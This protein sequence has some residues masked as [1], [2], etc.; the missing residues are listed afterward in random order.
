[1][2]VELARSM[3][4]RG[5]KSFALAAR[6]LPPSCRDDVA[7]LY[8]Y[9]RR[10]DDLIDDAPAAEQ[11]ARIEA[12]SAELASVYAR[13]PQTDPVLA[14]FQR[15]VL[16]YAIPEGYPRALLDGFRSDVGVVRIGTVSELLLYA[17]RVAGV[18]GLMSCRL[19]GVLDARALEH[20]NHLGIAMQLTN[21]C[22]DVAEDWG[23]GRVYLPSELLGSAAGAPLDLQSATRVE[24]A[25]RRLLELAD[26]YYA[27]GDQGIPA[28][29][30]RVA[31]AVRAARL[32]YAAIGARIAA[33][34]YDVHAGRA[35]VPGF[36]KLLLVA[37]AVVT[38]LASRAVAPLR[39]KLAAAEVTDGR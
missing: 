4:A 38:E 29:P 1:M 36:R 34:G 18:V 32:V 24:L 13:E 20:A 33:Q 39:R 23:K 2:S 6:V 21:V 14:E 35:V 31:I 7:V 17:H 22:R 8:A 11:P 37:R 28:L 10:A 27:S 12:L 15:V 3:L 9:C 16:H 25:L 26:R 19:F 30:L 5:S